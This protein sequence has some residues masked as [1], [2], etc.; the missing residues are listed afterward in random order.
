MDVEIEFEATGVTK[1]VSVAADATVADVRDSACNAFDVHPGGLA[2]RFAGEAHDVDT[3]LRDTP[4][5]P[6][7]CTLGP[8]GHATM[9]SL[10]TR[11]AHKIRSI[12]L[13]PHG[14]ICYV[15]HDAR[16]TA[17]CTAT[18]ETLREYNSGD[19]Y[20]YVCAQ[21]RCTRYLFCGTSQGLESFN[22]ETCDCLGTLTFAC[23]RSLKITPC[24]TL[25]VAA[26]QEQDIIAVYTL[27]GSPVRVF[28]HSGLGA[29]SLGMSRTSRIAS[30]GGGKVCVWDAFSDDAVCTVAVDVEHVDLSPCG[31]FL[32]CIEGGACTVRVV[33]GDGG[34]GGAVVSQLRGGGSYLNASYAP[35]GGFVLLLRAEGVVKWTPSGGHSTVAK[36]PLYQISPCSNFLVY[37]ASFGQHTLKVKL[38]TETD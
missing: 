20:V 7:T 12:S 30:C 32:L 11:L 27:E 4:Y 6:G 37:K 35:C 9:H 38:L 3:L 24:D 19:G 15:G 23:V 25:L 8:R 28:S 10:S 2:V 22:A 21:S 13:S 18:G 26:Q 14:D 31:G 29:R 36:S 34:G 1:V 17:L 33:E 5:T 16:I